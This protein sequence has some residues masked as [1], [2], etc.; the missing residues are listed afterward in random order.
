[1]SLFLAWRISEQSFADA[2][3]EFGLTPRQYSV[4]LNL[5]SD[6]PLSQRELVDRV[7]LDRSGM[8]RQIDELEDYGFVE[9]RRD[10]LDGRAHAVY[11]TASGRAR[12]R[13][14]DGAVNRTMHEVY[15][16]LSQPELAELDRLLSRIVERY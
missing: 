6:E 15:S 10:P 2:L 9:R 7:G 13:E 3:V 8:G 14:A 1:M 16:V 11:I 4:L 12:F 5:D